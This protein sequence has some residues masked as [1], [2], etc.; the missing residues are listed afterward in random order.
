MR[1]EFKSFLD[2][3]QKIICLIKRVA[4][5]FESVA[6]ATLHTP[7]LYS[8]FLRAL[9]SARTGTETHA[10][11]NGG[12]ATQPSEVQE[13]I[14]STTTDETASRELDVSHH[15]G[16]MS[17][18]SSAPAPTPD[19]F[20]GFFSNGEMGPV[21]DMSTFPPTMAPNPSLPDMSMMSMD[22]ILSADFW[23]SMLVP[24][25]L[26]LSNI[27]ACLAHRGFLQGSSNGMEGLSNGFVYGAGGSG[28][29][30]PRMWNSPLPSAD[31]SREYLPDKTDNG[32]SLP[33]PRLSHSDAQGR[34]LS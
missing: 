9:I 31:N 16:Q 26:R 18:S 2:H 11:P 3:E 25:M 6:V 14:T 22:S 5:A 12:P 7:A 15:D 27:Y 29:I 17:Q 1:P 28:L 23:D 19:P 21:A 8:V 4:D 24:G 33:Q 13:E 32:Y 34:S 20:A 30:T 10:M